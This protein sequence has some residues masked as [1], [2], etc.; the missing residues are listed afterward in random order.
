M[1]AKPLNQRQQ[2]ALKLFTTKWDKCPYGYRLHIATLLALVHKGALELR[3]NPEITHVLV[4]S[5]LGYRSFLYQWRRNPKYE[6]TDQK[7]G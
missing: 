5:G 1:S 3:P 4:G 7:A 2:D 6:A